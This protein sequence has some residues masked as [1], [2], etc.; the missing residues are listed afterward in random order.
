MPDPSQIA[1]GMTVWGITLMTDDGAYGFTVAAPTLALALVGGIEG[2][3]VFGKTPTSHL[4]ADR[5]ATKGAPEFDARYRGWLSA[6]EQYAI[7]VLTGRDLRPSTR[8]PTPSR[9]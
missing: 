3:R 1:D 8:Y 6:C 2:C 9:N 7:T 5:I 4:S